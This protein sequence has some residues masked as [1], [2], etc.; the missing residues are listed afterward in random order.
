MPAKTLFRAGIVALLVG[1][2]LFWSI[3][4]WLRFIE[5]Y[6]WDHRELA[7]VLFWFSVSLA[8]SGAL[9]LW[10]AAFRGLPLRRES[11]RCLRMFPSVVTRSVLPRHRHR[12]TP[13]IT[14]LPNFGLI[15]GA[16]LWILIVLLVVLRQPG[17]Y[18]GLPIQIRIHD[19]VIWEKSPWQET[20]SVYLAAGEKYYINGK[21]VPR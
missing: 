9:L 12:P 21:P 4:V 13:L 11:D 8:G 20:L 5:R 19:S 18:H 7:S 10:R 14:Q 17:H 3:P 1:I 6:P 2:F 15:Y 16:V